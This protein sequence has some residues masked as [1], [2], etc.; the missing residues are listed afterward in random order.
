MTFPNFTTSEKK[1]D[2]LWIAVFKKLFNLQIEGH[3]DH[4]QVAFPVRQVFWDAQ[5]KGFG[6]LHSKRADD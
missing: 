4:L 2:L 1:N 6:R 3:L 5:K